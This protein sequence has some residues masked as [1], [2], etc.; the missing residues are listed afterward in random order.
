MASVLVM[1]IT[2]TIIVSLISLIGVFSLAIKDK[3]LNKIIL[4]LVGFAAGA[5]I[6][7]AFLHLI[8]EA[9]EGAGILPVGILIITGFASFCIIERFLFWRHCHEGKCDVHTFTYMSIIGD[10]V[11]NL[12]DGMA[13]AGS[14]ILGIPTG[15]AA[16]AAII[17]HE[18][19]QEMGD[20]GILIYGGF[21]KFKAL[22]FNFFS[23]LTAV[24]GAV[25]GVYLF[26]AVSWVIPLLLAFTAG[27]FIY[28]ASSDLIPEL[29]KEADMD[30]VIYSFIFFIAGIAFMYMFRMI[31]EA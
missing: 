5:L 11:H 1:S 7:G 21:S 26:S 3:L 28:V 22:A 30:K 19:P 13:I 6:G 14:F 4:L 24:V 8:P 29:H 18:I 2:A 20:F 12:I 9:V 16:T 31:F 10:S 15:I 17:A 23:A 27:G 25:I